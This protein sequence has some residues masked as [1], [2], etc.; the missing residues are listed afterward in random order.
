MKKEKSVHG[1]FL[2]PCPPTEFALAH[3]TDSDS[4][5]P[6]HTLAR[7]RALGFSDQVSECDPTESRTLL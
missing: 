6:T 4:A 7:K 2:H 1:S 3:N 5:H